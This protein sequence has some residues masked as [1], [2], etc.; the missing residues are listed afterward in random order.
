MTEL[1]FTGKTNS[2]MS[3]YTSI[4]VGAIFFQTPPKPIVVWFDDL[5]IDDNQ[6][7]C[8]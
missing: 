2:R 6:I 7:G 5:A 8:Q 4:G 1:A 3:D